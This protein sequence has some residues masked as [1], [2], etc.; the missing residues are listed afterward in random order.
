MNR[1]MTSFYFDNPLLFGIPSELLVPD[2]IAEPSEL[3]PEPFHIMSH[4]HFIVHRVY[5]VF[6]EIVLESFL[7]KQQPSW[8]LNDAPV[9]P[10]IVADEGSQWHALAIVSLP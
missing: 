6:G 5:L 2:I 8:T 10:V 1:W 4:E 9:G 3:I 7:V